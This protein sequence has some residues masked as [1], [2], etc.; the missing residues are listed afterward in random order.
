MVKP[1]S[2]SPAYG[3]RQEVLDFILSTEALLSPVT[4]SSEL[5]NEECG[6]I[7]EYIT[8]LCCSDHPWSRSLPIRYN[9]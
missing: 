7:A 1:S 9:I 4:R 5:T 2:A 6:L 8:S 3:V